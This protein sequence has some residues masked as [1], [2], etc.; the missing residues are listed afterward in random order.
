MRRIL[1]F[2]LSA[3]IVAA[4]ALVASLAL[5]PDLNISRDDERVELRQV[6]AITIGIMFLAGVVGGSLANLRGLIKHSVDNDYEERYSLSYYLRP[7]SGGIC[8]VVVFFLLLG[9]AIT[10]TYGKPEAGTAWSSVRGRMPYVALA[11]LAGYG[12]TEFMMKLKELAQ[13]LF[14]IQKQGSGR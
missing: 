14:A 12:S 4:A 3:S 13:S 6:L 11:L 7:F 10:L 2:T 1:I 5:A 9:G 8:G